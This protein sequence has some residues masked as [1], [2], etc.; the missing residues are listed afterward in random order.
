MIS[1]SIKPLTIKEG[2]DDIR[3]HDYG[4]GA[5]INEW[6][7]LKRYDSRWSKQSWMHKVNLLFIIMILWGWLN[8]TTIFTKYQ[9]N[10]NFQWLH[11]Y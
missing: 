4:D 6:W 11:P 1:I 9:S 10:I 3:E 8:L 5:I 2:R 7:L